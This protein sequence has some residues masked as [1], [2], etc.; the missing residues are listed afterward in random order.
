MADSW[1]IFLDFMIMHGFIIPFC[2]NCLAKDKVITL[3]ETNNPPENR[4]SQKDI[5]LPTID[6]QG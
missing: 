1:K 2:L 4:P 6:F 5:H 3:P